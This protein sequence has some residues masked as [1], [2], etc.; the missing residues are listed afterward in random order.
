MLKSSALF[1]VLVYC[2]QESR[3]SHRP[4]GGVDYPT[5]NI[6]APGSELT[7]LEKCG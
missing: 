2:G 6:T 4:I 5:R 1:C 3:A 7:C